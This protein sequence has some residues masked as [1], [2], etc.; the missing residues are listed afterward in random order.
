MMQAR[1]KWLK[2][3]EEAHQTMGRKRSTYVKA[4]ASFPLVTA[5]VYF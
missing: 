1:S 4:A 5:C 2:R 3:E